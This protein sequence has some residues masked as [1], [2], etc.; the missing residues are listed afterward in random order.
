[1]G[2]FTGRLMTNRAGLFPWPGRTNPVMVLAPDQLRTVHFPVPGRLLAFASFNAQALDVKSE[3]R[4]G[5]SSPP[6]L[7]SGT[8]HPQLVLVSRSSAGAFSEMQ[9]DLGWGRQV[10]GKH[11]GQ[12]PSRRLL[13]EASLGSCSGW[14]SSPVSL[15]WLA[16]RSGSVLSA[17]GL[18]ENQLPADGSSSD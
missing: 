14:L 16:K 15:S 8:N 12:G 3:G 4:S 5:G 7:K 13:F 17:L 18:V 1:M 2:L 9:T 11:P 10:A 6:L